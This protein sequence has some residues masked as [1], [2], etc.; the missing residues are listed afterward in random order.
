MTKKEIKNIGFVSTRIA[1][2]DGVSLEIKKWTDVLERLG[3]TCFF[4]AGEIDRDADKSC[5]ADLAHFDHPDIEKISKYSFGTT[6]RPKQITSL[7]YAIKDKL[8]GYLEHL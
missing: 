8:K 4:F 2:T 3:Y 6:V 1:G 5:L 7:V